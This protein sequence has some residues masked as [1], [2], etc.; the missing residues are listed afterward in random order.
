[1]SEQRFGIS[2][3]SFNRALLTALGMGPKRSFVAVTDDTVTV[4]MGWAFRCEIPRSS[5]ASVHLDDDRVW[6]WGVHGWG[7]RWL[8]NGSS[9]GLVRVDLDPAVPSKAVGPFGVSL[10][11][12]RVSVDE[13][14]ALLA[15]L[16]VA[17]G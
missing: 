7:G 11:T 6:G 12:L 13:P 14:N 8:V 3:S 17:A 4:R 2:Y 5:I 9:A 16:G 1:M 10:R 15:E